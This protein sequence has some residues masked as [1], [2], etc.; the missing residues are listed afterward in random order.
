M[1][2]AAKVVAKEDLT[3][4]LLQ[5]YT[6]RIQSPTQMLSARIVWILHQVRYVWYMC[7]NPHLILSIPAFRGY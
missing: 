1:A 5:N 3:T 4:L 6:F 7:Y 2:F